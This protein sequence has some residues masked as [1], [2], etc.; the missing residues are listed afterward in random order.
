LTAE[1]AGGEGVDL[2]AILVEYHRWATREDHHSESYISSDLPTKHQVLC[3]AHHLVR[4]CENTYLAGYPYDEWTPPR[5]EHG[6]EEPRYLERERGYFGLDEMTSTHS[7]F[8]SS[9]E[10]HWVCCT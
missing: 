2:M 9:K 4:K 6:R 1:D 5:D 8:P 3:Q 10:S 7:A